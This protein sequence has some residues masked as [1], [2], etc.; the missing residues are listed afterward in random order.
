MAL[1]M[2]APNYWLTAAALI[3]PSMSSDRNL[4]G[5]G[6]SDIGPCHLCATSVEW[7]NGVSLSAVLR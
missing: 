7:I 4:V 3:L 5:N 1:V 2:I 6:L